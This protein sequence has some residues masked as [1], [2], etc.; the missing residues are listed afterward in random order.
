MPVKTSAFPIKYQTLAEDSKK[1][2]PVLVLHFCENSA[3]L[4]CTGN[5]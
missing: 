4:Y 5:F 2:L 3:L 1:L